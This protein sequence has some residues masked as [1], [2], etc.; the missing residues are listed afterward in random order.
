MALASIA[1]RAQTYTFDPLHAQDGQQIQVNAT[2]ALSGNFVAT[3][4]V[5]VSGSSVAIQFVQD[6]LN[7]SPNPV[8]ITSSIDTPPL[9]A[10]IYTFTITW[11]PDPSEYPGPPLVPQVFTIAVRGLASGPA[12]VPGLSVVGVASLVLLLTVA[13]C[14]ALRRRLI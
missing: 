3:K 8:F 10:G 7:L 5:T 12:T 14:G 2:W 9:S 13:G 11:T 6:G 4:S 1:A